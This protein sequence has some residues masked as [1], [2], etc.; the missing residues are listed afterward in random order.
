VL[1]LL[2]ASDGSNPGGRAFLRPSRATGNKVLE[3]S[4]TQA[5]EL[6]EEV[7]QE[8]LVSLVG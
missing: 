5:E 8:R 7:V 4:R 2:D 1:R 3:E 6:D